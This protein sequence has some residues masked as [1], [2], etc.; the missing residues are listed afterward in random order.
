MRQF[1][2]PY[3]TWRSSLPVECQAPRRGTTYTR[4]W[5]ADRR[6]SPPACA[7]AFA[8]AWS[9]LVTSRKKSWTGFPFDF[10]SL[11]E[12]STAATCAF[13]SS[14]SI[15]TVICDVSSVAVIRIMRIS[16]R[17]RS[18]HAATQLG[19]RKEYDYKGRFVVHWL[20]AFAL[21]PGPVAA[22]IAQLYRQAPTSIAAMRSRHPATSAVTVVRPVH[23]DALPGGFR[24]N[25]LEGN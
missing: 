9:T 12:V 15:V 4:P 23:M 25:A 1:R 21:R 2:R 3:L 11:Q 7:A 8:P 22:A 6:P 13:E 5:R 17:Q 24:L 19:G 18:E 14:P 16:S 10:A 20:R